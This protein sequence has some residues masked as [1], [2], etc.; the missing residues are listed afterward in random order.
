[1]P[2]SLG[3]SYVMVNTA[4]FQIHVVK[5]QQTVKT[6]RAIVG[7]TDRPTPVL[8]NRI[9]YLEM[10]PYWNIPHSIAVKDILPKI[11]QNPDY[12]KSN[13]IRVFEN[14][15]GNAAEI[16][17]E[18]IDWSQIT[19]RSFGFKLRQEPV[20]NNALGQ[21]K[22]MFPNKFAVYMHDTPGQHLFYRTKR[23]F[24]SGCVRVEKPVELA[25]CLLADDPDFSRD[26]II[27]T[28]SS[29]QRK[30]VS[31]TK[32]INIHI[33]YWTAWVAS[34][35]AVHFRPD[36]Y[37]KDRQLLAAMDQAA[38]EGTIASLFNIPR[39]MLSYSQPAREAL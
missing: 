12:L 3:Q 13:H 6:I 16:Q 25:S 33:L 30:I 32:P 31:L 24:S 5:N 22:F 39:Q 36:V 9:T 18:T 11:K 28:I 7:K 27:E 21:M 1:M 17:P 4:G 26:R 8:S 35:G 2:D 29:R 15:Q 37:G 19:K 38:S 20:A 14:W 23:T 34:D 10:N